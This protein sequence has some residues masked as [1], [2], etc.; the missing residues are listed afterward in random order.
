[1]YSLPRKKMNAASHNILLTAAAEHQLQ[2]LESASFD[3]IIEEA[4][5][6]ARHMQLVCSKPTKR[7][8][9]NS[10]G[11]GARPSKPKK[12][13]SDRSSQRPQSATAAREQAC[14]FAR[15]NDPLGHMRALERMRRH[16][17]RLA[18]RVRHP[19]PH[20]GRPRWRE[21]LQEYI[22]LVALLRC[23][24]QILVIKLH[25]PLGH[26]ELLT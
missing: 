17:R 3:H 19:L 21:G 24:V 8:T 7:A 13:K 16:R 5:K 20:Q 25:A 15:A 18:V 23:I 22:T 1:M 10:D 14:D 12:S 2:L 9:H 6:I 11:D 26:V 4:I